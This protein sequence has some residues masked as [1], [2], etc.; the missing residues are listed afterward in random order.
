MI[1]V[2]ASDAK[3]GGVLDEDLHWSTGREGRR[4]FEKSFMNRDE[5]KEYCLS[6]VEE[7]PDVAFWIYEE[8][9]EPEKVVKQKSADK[10][11]DKSEAT[12]LELPSNVSYIRKHWRGE[13]PLAVSFWINL[14]S[15]N[16]ALMF[17]NWLAQN[18]IIEH[19]Q[20]KY[21]IFA[22]YSSVK[23]ALIYP[24]QFIGLWR[25]CNRY[26]K[27]SGKGLWAIAAKIVVVIGLLTSINLVY[28]D[29]PQ[30]KEAYRLSFQDDYSNYKLTLKKTTASFISKEG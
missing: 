16:L 29:W 21:Q 9:L 6:M 23:F 8:N 5:A 25:A 20:V 4:I 18:S 30:Y 2:K 11:I 7:H 24:W 1:K 10:L 19:P 28:K 22:I 17:L 12:P 27:Q 3:T 26:V 13:L 15:L 14:I